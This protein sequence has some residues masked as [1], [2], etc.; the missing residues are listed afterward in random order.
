MD[1]VHGLLEKKNKYLCATETND[2]HFIVF[3]INSSLSNTVV[4]IT[5]HSNFDVISFIETYNV[6]ILFR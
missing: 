2:D 4:W 3:M 5:L 6:K 1:Y